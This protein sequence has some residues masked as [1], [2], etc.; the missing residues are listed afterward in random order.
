MNTLIK[1]TILALLFQTILSNY[2]FGQ[3][4]ESINVCSSAGKCIAADTCSCYSGYAGNNCEIKA[5]STCQWNVPQ[6][7][8]L[9]YYAE[10]ENG[11]TTFENDV[12]KFNVL[13]P[14]VVGRLNSS[15]YIQDPKY[16]AC[17]YPGNFVKQTLDL[18]TPKCHNKYSFS[19]PWIKAKECG[20]IL[21]KIDND[22]IYAAN[23][24]VF[25]IE[26]LGEIRGTPIHRSI[27][28]VIP[29]NVEFKQKVTVEYS[30]PYLLIK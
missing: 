9:D 29:L 5:P 20:W 10:L 18:S 27:L 28:K 3:S 14:L 25:Q 19:I 24:Y 12:L 8:K 16:S 23:L 26:T 6:H 4:S 11:T 15:I 1:I 21:N 17:S 7:L 30:E 22:T 13:V 2:C